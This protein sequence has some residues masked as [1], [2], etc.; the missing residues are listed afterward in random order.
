LAEVAYQRDDLD[1]ALRHLA[2]GLPLCRQFAYTQ[3]VTKG[4]TT[5]AWIRQ[6]NG[7][8]AGALDAIEEA[9]QIAPSPDVTDLLNPAPAQR[10]RLL[11][12]QGDI[13]AA[14]RWTAE[15]GLRADDEPH[16]PNEPAYLVL[17]RVLLAHDRPGQ[18]LDL[19]DRMQA[20]AT[21]QGRIG[22]LIEIQALHALTLAA[23]GA[24]NAAMAVLTEALKAGHLQGFLRV[25]TDE[26]QPMAALL[27]KL[28]AA[29][30]TQQH[31]PGDSVPMGYLD[32]LIRTLQHDT[33]ATALD[34]TPRT[35]LLPGLITPLSDR[36][37]EVLHLLAA[38]KQ[39]Q[40]IA[41]QLY[42]TVNTV[43][44]H[45]SHILDKLGAANRTEATAR[46]RELGVLR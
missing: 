36:E 24:H 4:L 37:L 44:K 17:A 38:G 6:A 16:Y 21:E 31:P 12:A 25:F 27:A 9:I 40:E 45:V 29:Q 33:A 20:A 8:M 23:D 7:D 34:T 41:N 22:S 43:K 42:V 18:A 35:M 3:S 1:V 13:E 32:R 5:M 2:E 11:L 14:A 10:A 19:L 30:R 46:A 28:I 15:R 26:G 39:N